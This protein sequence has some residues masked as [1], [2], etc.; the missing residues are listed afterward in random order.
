MSEWQPIETAPKDGSKHL[1]WSERHGFVVANQPS[2]QHI[3]GDWS[4]IRG[5]WKGSMNIAAA[6]AT[7]WAKLP[8]SPKEQT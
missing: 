2:A 8:K 4:L 1:L 6:C 5:R 7:H 3:P